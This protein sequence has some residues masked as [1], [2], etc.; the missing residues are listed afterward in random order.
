MIY[1]LT[2]P[3]MLMYLLQYFINVAAGLNPPAYQGW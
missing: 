1:R 2:A 3:V